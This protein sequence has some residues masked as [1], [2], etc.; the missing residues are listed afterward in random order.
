MTDKLRI[1]LAQLNL[2]VGDVAGNTTRIISTIDAARAAGAGRLR[3]LGHLV[4]A[5]YGF[6]RTELVLLVPALLVAEST[7]SFLGLGFP[8]P[9]P[10][11]GLM[12]QDASSVSAMQTAPWMLS[13][14]VFLFVGV[15]ALQQL[16][17]GASVDTAT[18]RR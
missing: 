8:E 12:L 5:S 3:L 6:L 14:A 17:G 16:G 15:L 10:S 18:P 11:W 13:P 4:P 9:V 7:I 1:G 2:V